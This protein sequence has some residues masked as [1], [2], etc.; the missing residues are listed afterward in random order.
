MVGRTSTGLPGQ[1]LWKGS[2]KYVCPPSIEV[3]ASMTCE[4]AGKIQA[5]QP[6]ALY[7]ASQVN[8]TIA[9]K[10]TLRTCAELV[11]ELR[12]DTVHLFFN[13]S[14]DDSHDVGHVRAVRIAR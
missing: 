11:S 4:G 3:V 1:P 12:V 10:I 13:F 6:M 14:P 2:P 9:Q 5:R 8:S 7:A